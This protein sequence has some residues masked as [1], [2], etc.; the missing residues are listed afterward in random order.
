MP[1]IAI[2]VHGGAGSPPDLNDGCER[3]AEAG[4]AVLAG[5]GSA[6]DAAIAAVVSLENDGRYNA[7]T[8]SILRL[9]G[10]TIEMD[11]SVM[12]SEGLI[13]AVACLQGVGNPVLVA[14][15]VA[16]T[17][18]VLLSGEGAIA[19]ARR[20]G[21][22][23]Y[24]PQVTD[25]AKQRHR[26]L[27]ERLQQ[28]APNVLPAAWEGFD[29]ERYW[30][31]GVP[32]K[33]VLEAGDTVGAVAVDSRGRYAVASSTGG[34]SPM[35][36][37]RIGDT[38]LPGCGFFAGRAGA[39]GITG[40]GEEIIK[41]TL[42]RAVYDRMASGMPAQA[43]CEDGLRLFPA[44]VP[45]GIIAMDANGPAVAANVPMAAGRAAE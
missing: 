5:G 31:F 39:V 2:Q 38:P 12:D 11:A 33:D 29:L 16:D 40:I 6:L 10:K 25:A 7:G 4:F 15:R 19:F 17:P 1:P 14:R 44:S 3:A 41:R 18:H 13:G 21:F 20:C 24:R 42:A 35:L 9:D 22:P 8:G 45:V 30:N 32:Y 23:E 34:S 28:H 43:A 36:R 37:G 27:V 26:R